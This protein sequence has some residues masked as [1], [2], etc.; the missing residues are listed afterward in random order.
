MHI[1]FI[2][3]PFRAKTPWGIEQNVRKAEALALKAWQAGFAV[4]CPHTNTRFFQGAAPDGTWLRGYRQILRWCDAVLVVPGWALSSGAL[5]EVAAAR[6]QGIPVCRSI[7]ELTR[8]LGD[9]LK[10]LKTRK[11]R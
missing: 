7:R 1:V 3:G 4:I 11:P 5:R 10:L 9:P 6:S 8:V 2:A